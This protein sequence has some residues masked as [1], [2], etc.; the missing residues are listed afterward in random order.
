MEK[1]LAHSF[2]HLAAKD[3]NGSIRNLNSKFIQFIHKNL[4]STLTYEG[5][6]QRTSV[7]EL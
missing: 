7:D 1:A 6:P 3:S 4:P 5:D 2:V